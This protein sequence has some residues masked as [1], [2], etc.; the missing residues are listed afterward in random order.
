MTWSWNVKTVFE[1]HCEYLLLVNRTRVVRT[2]KKDNRAIIYRINIICITFD[3]KEQRNVPPKWNFD[4]QNCNF[5]ELEDKN[6]HCFGGK[7]LRWLWFLKHS[8]TNATYCTRIER[9]EVRMVWRTRDTL[10]PR[11]LFLNLN[12]TVFNHKRKICLTFWGLATQYGN[13]IYLRA[14]SR[15]V[16]SAINHLN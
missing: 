12:T 1:Y 6:L 10:R 11:L 7:W 4:L 2:V 16:S 9:S 13:T 15:R 8:F 5:C 14:V 3:D